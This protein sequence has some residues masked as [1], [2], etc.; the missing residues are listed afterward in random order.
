MQN[1]DNSFKN[2][3]ILMKNFEVDAYFYAIHF[4]LK[5]ILRLNSFLHRGGR[6]CVAC[7]RL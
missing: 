6:K 7:R 2:S 5:I 4:S 3:V 1:Y